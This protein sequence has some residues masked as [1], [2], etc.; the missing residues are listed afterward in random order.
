MTT[1]AHGCGVPETSERNGHIMLYVVMTLATILLVFWLLLQGRV[2]KDD[3][4]HAA[5]GKLFNNTMEITKLKN[6]RRFSDEKL[7]GL[8][9]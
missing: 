7:G 5:Y 1:Y 2:T 6:R 8:P 4:T 3:W 9:P